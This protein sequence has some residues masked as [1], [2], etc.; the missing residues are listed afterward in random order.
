MADGEPISYADSC[1]ADN[2]YIQTIYIYSYI[3]IHVYIYVYIYIYIYTYMY[4]Y[5]CNVYIIYIYIYLILD[6]TYLNKPE[7]FDEICILS[8]NK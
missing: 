8:A 6:M 4:I 1:F 2:I 7:L 5:I 3:Y